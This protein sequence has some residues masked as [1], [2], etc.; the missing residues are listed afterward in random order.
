MDP[1]TMEAARGIPTE[2]ANY[3]NKDGGF[4]EEGEITLQGART[5]LSNQLNKELVGK[6]LGISTPY[7]TSNFI[8]VYMPAKLGHIFS[9][10]EILKV[11][12]SFK[13]SQEQFNP[14]WQMS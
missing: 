2:A 11:E 13:E 10:G 9:K 8:A 7:S 12:L 6:K 1:F 5:D 4:I 3:C 14:I